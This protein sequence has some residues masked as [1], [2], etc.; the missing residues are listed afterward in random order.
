MSERHPLAAFA[1]AAALSMAATG[2]RALDDTKYPDWTGQWRNASGGHFDPS[3][4][5]MRQQAPLTEEYQKI[6]EAGL[7][8]QAAGGQGNDP[9][10]RCIPP[11]MPR[12]AIVYEGMEIAITPNMVYMMIEVLNQLRRIQTNGRDFPQEIEPSFVGYSIGKWVDQ[13][14]DGR[15][16]TLLIETR[17]LKGP[18]VF[19]STGI[20]LHRD[21]QTVVKER[22]TQDPA[23][24]DVLHNEVTTIDH[25]LTHPWT[26]T[27]NYRREK[28]P[29]WTEQICA[30]ENHHVVI[31]KENYYVSQDGFLMPVR[32]NQPPP[33]LRFFNQPPN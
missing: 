30:E 16:D 1:L 18:R 32:K 33:D 14:G 6:F 11:G 12:A 26:V 25:A 24:R 4:P 27:R 20:P 8:D 2:A 9:M 5:R 15:Y 22:I 29:V 13:D 17:G 3:K 21:N 23:D 31:G 19:D 28:N 7:A 10:Y